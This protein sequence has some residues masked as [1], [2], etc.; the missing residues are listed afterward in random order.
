VSRLLRGQREAAAKRLPPAL[1][2]LLSGA[3]AEQPRAPAAAPL[4]VASAPFNPWPMLLLVGA[5]AVLAGVLSRR[6][7]T[8]ANVEGPGLGAGLSQGAAQPGDIGHDL[9]D[10]LDASAGVEV[11]KRFVFDHLNFEWATANLTP[12]SLPTLDRVAAALQAHPS[13]QV[14]LEGYTDATGVPSDNMRLS[15]AR[16]NTV[17]A[18]LVARGIAADR[19]TT[20][21]MGQEHPVASNDTEEGRARNRR[22][23]LM[24]THR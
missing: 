16:A 3:P 22:T 23:E 6:T 9:A 19:I 21:G 5:L 2:A 20:A 18:A 11:P 1:A 15:L 17:K 12:D 10:Y 4:R 7:H 13:A 24:V 14:V 8:G